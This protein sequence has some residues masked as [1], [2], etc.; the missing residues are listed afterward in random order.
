MPIL[1]NLFHTVLAEP[2]PGLADC[3]RAVAIRIG[4]RQ[5]IKAHKLAATTNYKALQSAAAKSS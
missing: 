5:A 3:D 2:E 4:S 1:C